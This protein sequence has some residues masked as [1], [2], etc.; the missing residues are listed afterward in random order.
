[1]R[2]TIVLGLVFALFAVP[3]V[4]GQQAEAVDAAEHAVVQPLDVPLAPVLAPVD[5]KGAPGY[6]AA[7]QVEHEDVEETAAR[8]ISARN[9]LAILG[10]VVVV[11][12]LISFLR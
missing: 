5:V 10:G 1:M 9:A 2:L 4:E 12:A 3:A 8:Q 6:A 11:V 7:V